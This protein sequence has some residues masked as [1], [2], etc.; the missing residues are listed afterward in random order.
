MGGMSASGTLRLSLSS[1]RKG[2]PS[3][4]GGFLVS[5]LEKMIQVLLQVREGLGLRSLLRSV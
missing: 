3:T 1:C 2:G 5:N 4:S